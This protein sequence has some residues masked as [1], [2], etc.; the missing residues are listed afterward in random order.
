MKR[1]SIE[2]HYLKGFK[3]KGNILHQTMILDEFPH[4]NF[5]LKEQY[6]DSLPPL[7]YSLAKIAAYTTIGGIVGLCNYF[8]ANRIAHT[9]P[10]SIRLYGGL[11][12]AFSVC[13]EGL[14]NSLQYNKLPCPAMLTCTVSGFLIR[15]VMLNYL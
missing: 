6:I 8:T 7:L 15:K 2:G 4:A 5:Q 9:I 10:K 3:I 14:A 13:N 12:F 11:L 1:E